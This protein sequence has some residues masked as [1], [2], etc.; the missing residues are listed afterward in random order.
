MTWQTSTQDHLQL[1]PLSL[2]RERKIKPCFTQV[3]K[4]AVE[5][6]TLCQHNLHYFYR[7]TRT[8]IVQHRSIILRKKKQSTKMYICRTWRKWTVSIFTGWLQTTKA[9]IDFCGS[10]S[11]SS[12]NQDLSSTSA[13]GT[14]SSDCSSAAEVSLLQK[15]RATPMYM[16]LLIKFAII[17]SYFIEA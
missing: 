13:S 10:D 9:S 16:H 1:S 11:Q 4:P 15:L 8:G 14:S 2:Q 12:S 7:I 5:R 17:I 6:R 3:L